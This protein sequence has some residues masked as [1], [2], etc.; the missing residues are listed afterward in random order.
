MIFAIWRPSGAI[1]GVGA[2]EGRNVG[3]QKNIRNMEKS[4]RAPTFFCLS[5]RPTP[6]EIATKR[7]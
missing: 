5:K 2:P 1:G 4:R 7:R 6:P 3:A